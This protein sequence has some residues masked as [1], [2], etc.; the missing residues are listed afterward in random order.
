MTGFAYRDGVLSVEGV[1][2]DAIA[3]AVGTPVYC[4]SSATLTDNYRA[5]ADAF[6]GLPVKICYSLKANANL[7]VVRTLAKLG[8]GADVVSGGELHRALAAGVPPEDIVFAGVGKTRD[9]LAAALEAGIHQ[10][11]VESVPELELLSATAQAMGVSA[12]VALR[13]NPNVDARTHAKI[14]TGRSEDKFGIDLATAAEVY[15]RAA[16]LPAIAPVGLAVHIGSQLT[17]LEPFR[18]AFRRI[19]DLAAALRADGHEVP[20][21]DLGGGLGIGYGAEGLPTQGDYAAV[22]RDTTG[23]LGCAITI[24]PGRAIAGPAGVLL[25]RVLYVKRGA[26][27]TFAIVD[28]AMNDLIRPAMYEAAHPITPVRRPADGAEWQDIDVVGPICESSDVFAR[29]RSLPPVAAGDLLAF[30]DAGAY[31]AVMSSSYNARPTPPEVL[32]RG[33]EFALTRARPCYDDMLRPES[34][35]PWLND[36][37]EQETSRAQEEAT[38]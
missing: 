2:L 20:R 25:T 19:A 30:G 38:A 10:I 17:D 8:A 37:A 21:L 11:N 26:T 23:H 33:E 4:Y 13:V 7:A 1:A 28:A 15:G 12:P 31:G 9:E 22:V 5:F 3:E 24:E 32:V 16:A 6:A 35:P 27:R 29:A 34:L 14:T 36:D 18:Q